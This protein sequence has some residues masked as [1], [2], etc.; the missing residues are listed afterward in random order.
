M[1]LNSLLNVGMALMAHVEGS[2]HPVFENSDP[3]NQKTSMA[4]D[5]R[6]RG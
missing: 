4:C 2:K 1:P 6:T 5:I 3:Q